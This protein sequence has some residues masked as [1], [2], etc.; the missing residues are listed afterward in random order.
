MALAAR[1]NAQDQARSTEGAAVKPNAAEST[2]AGTLRAAAEK[3]G[4]LVGTAAGAE[5][6]KEEKYAATLGREFNVLTPENAL[7]W[8][9]I[10]PKPGE[11]R[12]EGADKLVE[13]AEKHNMKV[14]GHTLVWHDQIPDYVKTLAADEFRKAVHEHIATLV[15]R[16]KGRIYEWDVVNEALDEKGELRKTIFLEKMGKNYIA[17][18]FRAAHEADPNALLFYNEYGCEGLGEKSDGQF[19]M[20]KKLI[21]EKVP[22]HGVGLQMHISAKHPPKP[23]DVAANVRRLAALG[24]RVQITEMDVKVADLP[25]KER[26]TKQAE[27]YR[28]IIEACEKEKGFEGVTFWGFTDKH[29]WLALEKGS[30]EAPLLFDTEYRPKPAYKAVREALLAK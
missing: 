28:K 18:V 13:F 26:A 2:E 11:W 4:L 8:G 14:R 15:G 29:S 21:E 9:P 20:L 27:V 24:L 5:E 30:T 19:K 25:E 3:R 10:H 12:F 23:E 17:E 6:L 1:V 7:K 22:I 16:Y